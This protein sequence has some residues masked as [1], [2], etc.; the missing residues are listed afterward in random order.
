MEPHP[1][2]AKLKDGAG[3]VEYEMEMLVFSVQG[4]NDGIQFPPGQHRNLFIEG[5]AI[6]SR[7]L[8]EFFHQK[9]NQKYPNDLR[10]QDF[11]PDWQC[12]SEKPGWFVDYVA[13]CNVLVAHISQSRQKYRAEYDNG[14]DVKTALPHLVRMWGWF[15]VE[16]EPER[17]RWFK[18]KLELKVSGDENQQSSAPEESN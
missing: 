5:F 17:R 4:L 14:I 2:P 15:L 1:E 12:D 8:L 11:V 18:T 16:L 13:K 9:K 6:H 3:D 7:N 10:A